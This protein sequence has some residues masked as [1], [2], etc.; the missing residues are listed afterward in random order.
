MDWTLPANRA[1]VPRGKAI[2][3]LEAM[4]AAQPGRFEPRLM[5]ARLLIDANRTDEVA[6]VLAA[7][8][9]EHAGQA[10]LLR[11]R[12][13]RYL[14]QAAE[15]VADL[16][17][18]VGLGV[19]E[20]QSDLAQ[21][22]AQCG[23]ADEAL[24]TARNRLAAAP[25][26][27]ACLRI[28]GAI[29]MACGLYDEAGALCRELWSRG[30]RHAQLVWTMAFAARAAGDAQTAEAL[31]AP[32]PWFA[33]TRLD[34]DNDALA[35]EILNDATLAASQDYKPTEGHVLRIDDFDRS[36]GQA[37]CALHA[38]VRIAIEGYRAER[39]SHGDHPLIAGWPERLS[40]ASWALAMTDDGFENWHIHGSSWL[41]A[42]YYVR[43]P[44]RDLPDRAG[45]I[46]FSALPAMAKMPGCDIEQWTI[47][48]EPGLLILFPSWYAHRTWP[49]GI[50]AERISV[51]FNAMPG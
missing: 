5:L 50:A 11:G 10:A 12:A 15:A 35:R 33:Q 46:G 28:A 42:V 48:P 9:P 24:A 29:M 36:H 37:A 25:A 18:A 40:L 2:A 17:L 27:I 30:V 31:L 43:N 21:A 16:H 26:D 32:A 3:N 23:R 49:T 41:S 45:H 47:A 44:A 20:A 13:L 39:T 7:P 34:I 19:M 38:A 14:D 22:L 8:P 6:R 4:V 51:A 1:S